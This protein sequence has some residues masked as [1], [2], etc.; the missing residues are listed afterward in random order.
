M[1]TNKEVMK[2]LKQSANARRGSQ[3]NLASDNILDLEKIYA[4]HQSR[5]TDFDQSLS[6]LETHQQRTLNKLMGTT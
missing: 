2:Y 4:N 3:G 1:G 6:A 5:P